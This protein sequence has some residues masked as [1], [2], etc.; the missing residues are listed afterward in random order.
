MIGMASVLYRLGR[1]AHRRR[2]IVLVS[3]LR[4]LLS[5]ASDPVETKTVSVA[6]TTALA[7]GVLA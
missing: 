4:I 1:F 5:G 7:R 2:L 6:G 3:R